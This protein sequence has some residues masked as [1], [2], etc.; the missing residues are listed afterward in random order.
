MYGL[1]SKTQPGSYYQLEIRQLRQGAYPAS[2]YL[3][4]NSHFSTNVDSF[5]LKKVLLDWFWLSPI[6]YIF[7]DIY[8]NRYYLE[9]L[10]LQIG[11]RNNKKIV[12]L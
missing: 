8:C 1:G 10:K 5:S 9:K 7:T 6:V 12:I 3:G 2:K 11:F 4:I